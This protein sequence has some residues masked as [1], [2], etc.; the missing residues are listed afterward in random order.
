MGKSK[1]SAKRTK[2]TAQQFLAKP[3][4]KSKG[5]SQDQSV[6]PTADKLESLK[7]AS[8]SSEDSELDDVDVQSSRE[9]TVAAPPPCSQPDKKGYTDN[10]SS[11]EEDEPVIART[12]QRIMVQLEVPTGKPGPPISRQ[13]RRCTSRRQPGRSSIDKLSSSESPRPPTNEKFKC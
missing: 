1:S 11:S 13:S 12:R 2:F 6:I 8:S 3:S 4:S 10:S 5:P 9:V 7:R